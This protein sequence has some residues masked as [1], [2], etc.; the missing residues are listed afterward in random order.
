WLPLGSAPFPYTTL[1]RSALCPAPWCALGARQLLRSLS[2]RQRRAR[3]AG[4][5]AEGVPGAP[6]RGFR[7]PQP[8]A[9]LPAVPDQALLRPLCRSEEHT[10]EL[11]SRENLVC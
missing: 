9:A 8:H 1:F 7:V 6:V 10:S 11:Q 3:V 4:H 5:P 2:Q